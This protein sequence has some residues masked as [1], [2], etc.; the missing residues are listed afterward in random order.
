MKEGKELSAIS[1]QVNEIIVSSLQ[2]IDELCND[3]ALGRYPIA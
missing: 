2:R 3:L 1:Q